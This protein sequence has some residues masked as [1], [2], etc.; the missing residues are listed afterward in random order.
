MSGIAAIIRFDGGEVEQGRI[1]RMTGAMHYRGIDGIAHWMEGPAALGHCMLRTTAESL[2]EEQPLRSEDGSLIL[3]MDGWLSN[4]EEL[5]IELLARGARLRTRSDAELVLRAYEEWG[6]DCPKHIDGEYAFL[7]W[8]K[9]RQEA[10]CARDHAG[11]RPLHYCRQGPLLIV[12]SDIAGV[13][14]GPAIAARPNLGMFAE[15]MGNDWLTRGETIWQGVATLLP[16][17]WRRFGREREQA[18]QYWSPLDVARLHYGRDEDYIEH[19]REVFADCVR[20]AARTHLPLGIDVSGGLDSSAV[21]VMALDQAREGRLI[22]PAIKGYTLVFEERGS[23]ADEIEYAR[24][25]SRHVGEPVREVPPCYPDLDW[26]RSRG[27]ADRDLPP[28]PN[29][30]ASMSPGLAA[31]G[32]GCRVIMNGL[33][34][35]EFI[36]GS[37]IYYAERLDAGDWKGFCRI[38]RED[39]AAVGPRLAAWWAFRFGFAQFLP[40]PIL[41]LRLKVLAAIYPHYRQTRFWL[42]PALR[43]LLDHRGNAERSNGLRAIRNPASRQMAMTLCY[44]FNELCRDYGSRQ[45]ARI[46]FEPRSPMYMRQFIEFA[47]AIPERMRHRGGLGKWLHRRALAGLLPDLVTDRRDKAEFTLAFARQL[48]GMRKVLVDGLSEEL[49]GLLN[50]AGVEALYDRYRSVGYVGNPIWPLWGIFGCMNALQNPFIAD[51]VGNEA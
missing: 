43:D 30:A 27:W 44:S 15:I 8:D 50:R 34:G 46:G 40:P 19:Y 36:E 18:C 48:D 51:V 38:F 9:R 45:A 41:K 37:Q 39:A 42:A 6:E 13:L 4:W 10:F 12:A 14:A 22:A 21:Y 24:A 32:D 1:E 20:R 7:V 29:G 17:H 2:E 47:F 28:F 33:G 5:R 16:A 25:V 35:D 3:V 26:F 23:D 11:R 31:V 49:S